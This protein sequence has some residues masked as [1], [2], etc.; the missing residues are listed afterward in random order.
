MRRPTE[1]L[2][3]EL[4]PNGLYG[5]SIY[6]YSYVATLCKK[7]GDE[8]M[9]VRMEYFQNKTDVHKALDEQYPGWKLKTINKLYEEDFDD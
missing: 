6:K 3:R 8:V 1:Q 7:G 2:T 4:K 9:A 5:R